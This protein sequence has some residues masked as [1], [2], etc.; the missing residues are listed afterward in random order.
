MILEKKVLS[1]DTPNGRTLEAFRRW[2]NSKAVPVL[3]GHDR[4]LFN[5]S[6]DLVALAPVDSDRLNRILRRYCGWFLKVWNPLTDVHGMSVADFRK[7][8]SRVDETH[9]DMYYFSERRIQWIGAVVSGL[10][11]AL[12]LV[13]AIVCLLFVSDKGTSMRIGMIVLFTCLFAGVVSL[14]TNARRAEIFASTAA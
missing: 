12:L 11:S 1:L 5:Q 10:F 9:V 4:E 13:G 6:A 8:G 3:W 2:F 14:L 7:E